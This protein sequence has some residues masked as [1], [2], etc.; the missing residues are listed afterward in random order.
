MKNK[1][2]FISNQGF[3]LFEILIAVTI[4]AML[5]GLLLSIYTL[6]LKS[7]N[8]GQARAELTQD[9]RVIIERITRDIRQARAIATILP[10]DNT[11]PENP[12]PN[13]IEVQDGHCDVLQYIKYYL[14]G[15]NLRRQIRQ[16]YFESNPDIYVPFD[17]DDGL[18]N[19]PEVNIVS[20]NLVGQYI[21]TFIF[22]GDNPISI[23]LKV[24][25]NNVTHSTHT[26]IYGKN[27]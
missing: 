2:Y 17:A 24:E 11:N 14:S 23:E 3:T 13:E 22:Y 27:L 6:S 15:E 26:S 21:K 18:G 4:G 7:L 12:A 16:Y 1:K 8:S 5:L 25:K 20:D 10:K 9:S 19:P